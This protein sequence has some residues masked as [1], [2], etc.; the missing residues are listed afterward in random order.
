MQHRRPARSPS[1]VSALLVS[2]GSHVAHTMIPRRVEPRRHAT[3]RSIPVRRF[4]PT[5]RDWGQRSGIMHPARSGRRSRLGQPGVRTPRSTLPTSSHVCDIT[6]QAGR[7]SL[8]KLLRSDAPHSV[9]HMIDQGADRVPAKMALRVIA[10]KPPWLRRKALLRERNTNS[11]PLLS[12]DFG[13][14]PSRITRQR[15]AL[16]EDEALERRIR[17]R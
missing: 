10:E 16:Q 4:A 12:S 8:A 14:A 3:S 17:S 7:S 15:G 1:R 9:V 13:L 5:C 2:L 6:N 11:A